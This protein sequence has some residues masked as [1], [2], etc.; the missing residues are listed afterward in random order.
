MLRRQGQLPAVVY[1][2]EVGNALIQVPLRQFQEIISKH[3]VGST[4]INLEIAG[5][6]DNGENRSY[7]VMIREVQRDPI[8]HQLLHADFFQVSL[9]EEIE[10]EIPVHL[11]GEAPGVKEGGV[12]Q[13][14]LREVT[15]SGLPTQ[16][17]E[18]IEADISGLGI[19]DELRVADLQ[20][21]PGVKILDEP[22]SIIVLVVPPVLEAEAE[23]EAAEEGEAATPATEAG[24]E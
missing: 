24:E 16:L 6:D 14:M 9:S 1:G 22:D 15:V 17:P 20:V 4:L 13:H 7:L 3:P 10:T 18:Y 23:E 2:K 5:S 12:L 11:V 19:G 21:P 8:R